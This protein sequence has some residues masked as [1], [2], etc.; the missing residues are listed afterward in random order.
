MGNNEAETPV[1]SEKTQPAVQSQDQPAVHPYPDWATLQAYY[2]PG[3]MP[4]PYFS[5]V[6]PPG[7]APHP[8]M[9]GPQPL[10]SPFGS[11]YGAIYPP[12][13]VYPHPALPIMATPVS[14]EVQPKT[15]GN[16]DKSLVKKHKGFDGLATDNGIAENTDGTG[17]SQS[18]YNSAEGSTEGSDGNNASGGTKN[19]RKR[20]TEDVTPSGNTVGTMPLPSVGLRVASANKAKGC[21]THLSPSSGAVVPHRAGVP[22]ELWMQDER[23][24]KRERRK[25][26]NRESAR[27]SRLRKQAE[28][29]ELAIKVESLSA[30]NADIRAEINQ[31]VESSEKL[32]KEN[33]SLMEKLKNPQSRQLEEEGADKMETGKPYI[34][35][36]FLSIMDNQNSNGRNEQKNNE[37]N[38]KSTGRLHQLLDPSPRGGAVAAS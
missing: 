12:G 22:S 24:L 3:M 11:P 34:L 6:V 31:L 13:G 25:Q 1:K 38:E 36:N 29:E 8:Y 17:Q 15:S 20:S 2:G 37:G 9:W 26:S 28:T 23:E 33:S 5:A 14:V 19:Q 27:R 30:E 10:I 32:R 18:G 21:S 4:P 7:H 16:N 35:E